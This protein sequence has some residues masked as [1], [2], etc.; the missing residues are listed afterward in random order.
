MPVNNKSLSL[1]QRLIRSPI[2]ACVAGCAILWVS[3]GIRQTFGAFLIP[4]TTET[5]W[6]RSTYSIAAALLQLLW[7]FSQPFLVYLAERKVGFGKTIFVA[8][9]IYGVGCFILYASDQSSGL[10]IF[11]M[12]A[13][14]GIS[15]GGNSFPNVL[16][17]VGRRFP[18]G[19]KHQ[20][21]AFGIVSSFGSFGQCCFLPIARAMLT[22]IG[23][24]MSFIVF[25]TS[26]CSMGYT[27]DSVV[28]YFRKYIFIFIYR[29]NLYFFHRRFHSWAF[30]IGLLFTDS[31][32]YSSFTNQ[33]R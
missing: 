3:F 2:M 6:P 10:F 28:P 26:L 23:W 14:I 31:T 21:I 15:A 1:N 11:A 8:C 19:S 24:R 12:G 4:I 30:S 13:V 22:S 9:I 16:A 5:G 29:I 27:Y 33:D 7:G 25:G 18:Q 20:S 32:T 17:S